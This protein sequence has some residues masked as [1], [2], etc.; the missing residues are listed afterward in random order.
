MKSLNNNFSDNTENN[1]RSEYNNNE[2]KKKSPIILI[3]IIIIGLLLLGVGILGGMLLI[4]NKNNN[5]FKSSDKETTVT[6]DQLTEVITTET[7]TS[8]TSITASSTTISIITTIPTTTLPAISNEEFN[9]AVDNFLLSLSSNSN[10]PVKD[11]QYAKYDVN[12]DGIKELFV[13]AEHIAGHYTHMYMY[14][15]GSFISTDVAGNGIR[16]S[17]SDNLIECSRIGGGSVYAYYRITNEGN[18]ELVEQIYSYAGQYT[19][20]ETNISESEF[21]TLLSEKNNL[22][23]LSP[24]YDYFTSSNQTQNLNIPTDYL[25][26]PNIENASTDMIFYEGNE[27]PYGRVATESSGLNLRKGPNTSYDVIEEL[28]KGEVV[29]IFGESSEWYYVGIN[30]DGNRNVYSS[31]GYVS[32]QFISVLGSA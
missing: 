29:W 30:V 20:N 23:W 28:P 8:T 9:L 7:S 31:M 25:N 16:F 6:T 19:H 10:D 21:N 32:K 15:N 27:H 17:V 2:G 14:K 13:S 5:T 24:S 1:N 4:K 11:I 22:S 18:I 3:L 26:F 12:N